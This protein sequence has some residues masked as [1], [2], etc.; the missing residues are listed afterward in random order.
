LWHHACHQVDVALW[1]LGATS[2]EHVQAIV[3]RPHPEFG[4]AMD[5]SLQFRTNDRQIVT[6]ALTYNTERLCWRVQFIGHEDV[7]TY[8][9]GCLVDEQ[10]NRIGNEASWV[11]LTAQNNALL[12]A[13]R[14]G[15]PSD[16]DLDA[17]L[18]AMDVLHRAQLSIDEAA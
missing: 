10:G 17:V 8:Q 15:D 11:D 14:S 13:L 9:N 18:P 2:I 5:L 16:F 3:G 1:V 7:L 4:M 12:V 6:H